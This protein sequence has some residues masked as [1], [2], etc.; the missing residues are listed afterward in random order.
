MTNDDV[1]GLPYRAV[2]YNPVLNT[3]EFL[4]AAD[5]LWLTLLDLTPLQ[6]AQRGFEGDR[7][8]RDMVHPIDGAGGL[9]RADGSPNNADSE[10]ADPALRQGES[11]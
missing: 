11:P 2:R 4:N 5:G 3:L 7:A 6:A 9:T 10:R 8:I 1:G